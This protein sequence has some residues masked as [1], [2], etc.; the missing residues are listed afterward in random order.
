MKPK[1]KL[2]RRKRGLRI[3]KIAFDELK[4]KKFLVWKPVRVKFHSQDIFGLFDLIALNKK[5]LKLI[6]V[7]KERKRFYK[8]R[9]I[10]KLPKP[11]KV[12]YELWIYKPKTKKFE[13]ITYEP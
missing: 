10:L 11:R 4:R 2:Q 1:R 5:E 8:N 6:Q 9:P 3:E 7:Q 12:S 13:I